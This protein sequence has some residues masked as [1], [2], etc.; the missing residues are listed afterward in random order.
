[1][2]PVGQ[3]FACSGSFWLLKFLQIWRRACS[4][5]QS[6]CGRAEGIRH[7][8][9]GSY[10]YSSTP[11][12]P[13][14]D[15]PSYYHPNSQLSQSLL[16]TVKK[17][18]ARSQRDNDLIYHQDV[19]SGSALPAIPETNLVSSLVPPGLI[20]PSSVLGARVPLFNDLVGWGAQEA[21]SKLEFYA[22]RHTLST[23]Q[24]FITTGNKTLCKITLLTR[25]G[26]SRMKQ[27][28]M[29]LKIRV[30]NGLT[31]GDRQL[32]KLNLPAS[33]EA[34]E[35]PIGLP[36]S[37]LKKAEEVRIEDGPTK[38]EASIEDVQ[39]L[40]HHDTTILDEVCRF[41]Y[42]EFLALICRRPW[43]S[44]ITKRQRTKQQERNFH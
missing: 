26:R 30:E 15:G 37:L 3:L 8:E 28:S 11:G 34:L 1:M 7:C 36:P 18:H 23:C 29:P 31:R 13:S 19:P 32:R 42:F 21:I 22:S 6:T 5:H 40:A 44:W 35:R 16:E 17:S 25:R 43:I 20:N 41:C 2:R 14:E 4:T 39:R 33:L 27:K 10:L 24:T 9:E 12:Y 38:I